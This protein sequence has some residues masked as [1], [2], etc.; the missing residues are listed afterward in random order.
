MCS[1]NLSK[2]KGYVQH[3]STNSAVRQYVA[4]VHSIADAV[5]RPHAW[6]M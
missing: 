4:G 2:K 3:C 6:L 1:A 5:M